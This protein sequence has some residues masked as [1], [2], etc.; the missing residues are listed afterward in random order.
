M[1]GQISNSKFT[2]T[3]PKPYGV[4]TKYAFVLTTDEA[5]LMQFVESLICVGRVNRLDDGQRAL[6]DI[7]N[8]YDPDEAWHYIRTE[9][10]EEANYVQLDKIWEDALWL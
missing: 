9:L 7:K 10:E 2:M 3:E 5:R 8:E 6:V 4:K 1:S